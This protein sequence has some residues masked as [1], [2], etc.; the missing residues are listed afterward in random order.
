MSRILLLEDDTMIA[1]G[2]L[3]ALETEG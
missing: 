2:I 1:S 3:Y